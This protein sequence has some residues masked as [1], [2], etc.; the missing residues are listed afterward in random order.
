MIM[1]EIVPDTNWCFPSFTVKTIAAFD[2]SKLVKANNELVIATYR[3]M[4]VMADCQTYK[5]KLNRLYVP[6]FHLKTQIREEYEYATGN[7]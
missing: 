4:E 3:G 1:A 5:D 6:L 7:I 2:G